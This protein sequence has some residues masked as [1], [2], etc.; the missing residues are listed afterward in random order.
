VSIDLSYSH[1][2]GEVSKLTMYH[3][4]LLTEHG[5][6][7]WNILIFLYN[8]AGAILLFLVGQ[9]IFFYYPE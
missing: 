3:I 7:A 4:G 2:K 1:Y 6:I 9:Y 5:A 8:A